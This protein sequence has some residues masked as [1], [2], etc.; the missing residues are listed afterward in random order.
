MTAVYFC[1]AA[2]RKELLPKILKKEYGAPVEIIYGGKPR[3]KNGG[4]FFNLSHSGELC[5][6]AVSQ[7]NIGIDTELLQTK[8][9][10]NVLARFPA[11]ER[12]EI[13]CDRDFFVHWTAREAY[14]K[15]HGTPIFALFKR[16]AFIGGK[17]LLDN[18]P[19]PEKLTFCFERGAVTAVCSDE[20]GFEIKTLQ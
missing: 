15:L 3:A 18:R 19:V 10:G 14:A 5:A 8:H 12:R 2:E 17:L 11:E 6:I 20:E 1:N 7:T 16:L 4:I 9:Y 13:T